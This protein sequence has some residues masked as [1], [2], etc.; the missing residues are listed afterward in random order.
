MLFCPGLFDKKDLIA[1]CKVLVHDDIQRKLDERKRMG[2][3]LDTE[4][5]SNQLKLQNTYFPIAV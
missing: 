5:S 3:E 1:H 2:T 4:R